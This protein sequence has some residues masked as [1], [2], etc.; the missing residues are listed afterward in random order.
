VSKIWEKLTIKIATF[1]KGLFLAWGKLEVE[2]EPVSAQ[3]IKES[4]QEL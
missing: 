4:S 2:S 3:N 1:L